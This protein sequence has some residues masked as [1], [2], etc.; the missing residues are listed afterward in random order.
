MTTHEILMR[1]PAIKMLAAGES[2]GRAA[3]RLR[4]APATIEAWWLA[5]EHRCG[6][7]GRV[8]ALQEW[9]AADAVG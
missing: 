8:Q 6:E 2:W 4:V 5:Y 1:G 9:G 7:I 3:R